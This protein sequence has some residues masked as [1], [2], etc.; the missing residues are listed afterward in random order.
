MQFSVPQFTDVEDKIIGPLTIKQF[1]IL[2]GAG[3]LVFLGFSAGGKNIVFGIFLLVII[4]LP[5]LGL[6]FVKINGRPLYN[7]FSYIFKFLTSPKLLVFHKEISQRGGN[8]SLKTVETHSKT[9][10]VGEGDKEAK[11]PQQRL[12]EVQAILQKQSEEESKLVSSIKN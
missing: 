7:S 2:F 9:V 10:N 3:V 4:G 1:G 12:L 11:S 5:A 6:A 8:V